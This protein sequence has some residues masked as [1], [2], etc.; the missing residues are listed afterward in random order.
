MTRCIV[1]AVI[2]LFGSFAA[3]TPVAWPGGAPMHTVGALGPNI[4]GLAVDGTSGLWAVRDSGSLVHL[5]R[6][7]T[8][9][10]PSAGNAGERT[11]HYPGGK[12]SPDSEGVTTADDTAAVYVAAERNNEASN[13]SHNSVMR[14]DTSGAGALTATME[15]DLASVFG[16][17]PANTGVESVTWIPD[18][19]FAAMGLRTS[20]GNT[21]APANY[22]DHGTGLFAT[23]LESS[24]EIVFLALHNDGKVS[25]IGK[26]ATGLDAI[27]DLSWNGARGELWAT[28][29]NHCSGQA[30]V[31]NPGEGAF[32]VGA[33]VRPPAGM[34]AINDEGFAILPTC[35]DGA[36]VA[37]WSDDSA[38]GGTSL[39]EAALPCDPLVAVGAPGGSS[40]VVSSPAATTTNST[41]TI[42]ATGATASNSTATTAST[43]VPGTPATTAHKSGKP[44][45]LIGVG[46][47]A[48]G[49]AAAA[50][51]AATIR[52][53]RARATPPG[54]GK[55]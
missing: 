53:R 19:V 47:L 45:F 16:A 43:T 29:D 36:M 18:A 1:T 7:G 4:S 15:W 28:C 21:Y 22:P 2:G 27:M 35:T 44:G 50:I 20:N 39:R 24:G 33:I 55:Q 12:G 40:T 30:A 46:T 6:S 14:F 42:A 52:K 17:T 25:T 51:A 9:W 10:K 41:S 37:V 26:V 54:P 11:L 23:A 13:T 3:P 49:I 34:D 32:Q 5:E 8:G 38:T 48:V 31:L